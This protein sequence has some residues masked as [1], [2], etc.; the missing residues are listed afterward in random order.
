V[1]LN[2]HLGSPNDIGTKAADGIIALGRIP[3]IMCFMLTLVDPR[4]SAVETIFWSHGFGEPGFL[5]GLPLT[6]HS[7]DRKLWLAAP[8]QVLTAR[9]PE[10]TMHCSRRIGARPV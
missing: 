8:E 10:P 4:M 6:T 5:C 1:R 2:A 9:P 7:V 3:S